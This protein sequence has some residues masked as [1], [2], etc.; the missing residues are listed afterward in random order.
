M[1]LCTQFDVTVHVDVLKR[2]F[3]DGGPDAGLT[4]FGHGM[5]AGQFHVSGSALGIALGDFHRRMP[6]IGAVVKGDVSR[7]PL[8]VAQV[9][10]ELRIGKCPGVK[11]FAIQFQF[12]GGEGGFLCLRDIGFHDSH[13]AFNDVL[14]GHIIARWKNHG[15]VGKRA[16]VMNPKLHLAMHD[17]VPRVGQQQLH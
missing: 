3:R 8:Q 16:I 7:F 13:P 17:V 14:D 2:V 4:V 12:H 6:L 9:H 10:R 5:T 1:I 15:G 11:P